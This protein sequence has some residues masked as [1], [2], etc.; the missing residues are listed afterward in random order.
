MSDFNAV[1]K[2]FVEYYYQTFDSNRSGLLPLY[3]SL[4]FVGSVFVI[5]HLVF[6]FGVC[7]A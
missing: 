4:P 1:A 5:S 3:V 7:V 2:S 6:L